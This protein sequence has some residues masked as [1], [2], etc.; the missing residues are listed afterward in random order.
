MPETAIGLI[1]DNGAGYFLPKVNGG[2]F[3]LGL[4]IA[5]TG[6][7]MKGRELVRYG[8]ATH[9]VLRDDI[10][11]IYSLLKTQVNHK[12]TIADVRSIVE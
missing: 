1:T 6:Y 7:R 12:S 5:L 9:F 11:K 2:D 10:K 8:L 3:A 4:Y